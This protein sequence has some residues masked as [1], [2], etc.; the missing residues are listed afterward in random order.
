MIDRHHRFFGRGSLQYLFRR[1]RNIGRPDDPLR[2]RWAFNRH[3]QTARLA[4]VVSKKI[5]KKAVVRNRIRRRCFEFWR[6]HLSGLPPVDLALT[7]NNVDLADWPA[8]RLAEANRQ[9]LEKLRAATGQRS[10][11]RS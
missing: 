1:G 9:L 10:D 4:V 7:V 2:L 8:S 11:R 6:S 5:S 3:R